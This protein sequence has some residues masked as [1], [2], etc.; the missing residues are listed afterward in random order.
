MKGTGTLPPELTYLSPAGVAMVRHWPAPFTAVPLEAGDAGCCPCQPASSS[1][2]QARR[3][4][5]SKNENSKSPWGSILPRF[6]GGGAAPTLRAVLA[7][8]NRQQVLDSTFLSYFGGGQD[9][10]AAPSEQEELEGRWRR[11]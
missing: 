5:G 1:Y 6:R 4:A 2:F 7:R 10:R 9:V 8:V 11:A 3:Q